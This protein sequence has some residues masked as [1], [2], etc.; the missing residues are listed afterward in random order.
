MEP[1]SASSPPPPLAALRL[2][3][4][5]LPKLGAR[6]PLAHDAVLAGFLAFCS[7]LVLIPVLG[8]VAAQLGLP[9]TPAERVTVM[10]L[11]TVQ[12]LSLVLRRVRPATC[13]LAV[14][15]LQ[16]GVVAVLPVDAG[17]RLAAPVVAAYSVGAYR[18]ARAALQAVAAAIAVEVLGGTAAAALIA[19]AARSLLVE[20]GVA[21]STWSTWSILVPAY[22]LNQVLIVLL[23][24]GAALGGVVVASRRDYTSLLQEQML[25]LAAQEQSRVRAAVA[26]ERSRM[27]RELHDIA[28][29]HLSGLVLQA[30]AVERLIDRDRKAAKRATRVV[31]TEGKEA[32]TNLRAVIGVLREEPSPSN[33]MDRGGG[34]DLDA[35]AGAP[36]PGLAVVDQ[37]LDA[38]R[39]SGDE[40][41]VTVDGAPGLLTPLADI[42]VYRVLQEALAN[43]RQHAPGERVRVQLKHNPKQVRLEVSNPVPESTPGNRTRA[44]YGLVGMR[45][46]AQLSGATLDAGRIEGTWRVRLVVPHAH[47]PTSGRV[48]EGTT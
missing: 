5:V 23:G 36:V 47:E 39:M 20:P 11:V 40:L 25:V 7:L 4:A 32:L 44:G 48:I 29:H 17:L 8:P 43:A 37:L 1:I 31:R 16:V 46:R 35:E 45:E 38:A 26:T 42:T 30:A 22:F 2:M 15:I 27:A 10:V 3:D 18:P 13:L 34:Q 24:V 6:G 28:A 21:G 33:L 12:T 19:P 9:F 14:T 41:D